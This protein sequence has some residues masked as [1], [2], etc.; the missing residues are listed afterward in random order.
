MPKR[1]CVQV[2]FTTLFPKKRKHPRR[3]L[4]I[5]RASHG[6][7]AVTVEWPEDGRNNEESSSVDHERNSQL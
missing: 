2:C 3:P 4:Y 7:V 1:S 5:L 6:F